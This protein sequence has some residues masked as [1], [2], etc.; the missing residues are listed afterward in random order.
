MILL[1]NS[2]LGQHV[3]HYHHRVATPLATILDNMEVGE[4]SSANSLSSNED[5]GLENRLR[6][7]EADD[8]EDEIDG[9]E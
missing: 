1:W 8:P 6:W 7:C 3:L 9:D 5:L 2:T 4:L